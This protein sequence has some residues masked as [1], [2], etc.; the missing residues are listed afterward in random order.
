VKTF[1]LGLAT[2]TLAV[3][4]VSQPASAAIVTGNVPLYFPTGTATNGATSPNNSIPTQSLTPTGTLPVNSSLT[5]ANFNPGAFPGVI[6][7]S[8][9]TSAVLYVDYSSFVSNNGAFDVELLANGSL[10]QTLNIASL[11]SPASFS[12]LSFNLLGGFF[13]ATTFNQNVNFRYVTSNGAT[14]NFQTSFVI[15]A[16]PEPLT[17]AGLFVFGGVVA[18]KRRLGAKK[19]AQ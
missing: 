14:T 17:M 8:S 15:T 12:G 9:I 1:A 2:A 19:A 6:P 3:F 5:T 16:V 13:N 4:V 10:V 18:T 11:S 7:F